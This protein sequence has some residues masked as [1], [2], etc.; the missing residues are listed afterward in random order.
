MAAFKFLE[1][2][3]RLKFVAATFYL[4]DNS[5]DYFSIFPIKHFGLSLP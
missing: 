4:P 3:I 1:G 5:Q 2:L